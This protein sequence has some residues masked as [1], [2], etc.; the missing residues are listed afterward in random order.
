MTDSWDEDAEGGAFGALLQAVADTPI[1]SPRLDPG[2][3]VAT[4]YEII[5]PLGE[6]G[7]GVVFLAK[8][9]RLGRFVA[10]K[11]HNIDTSGD[12][13]RRALREASAMSR[14]QDP[15]V[16]AV[17][18][19]GE[20][21]EGQLYIA[22]EHV[23]GPTLRQWLHQRPRSG[24]EIIEAFLE[25]AQGL[26]AAHRAG[27]VH[28]DVKPDNLLIGRDG[29]VRVADFGLAG[30]Q[31]DLSTGIGEQL[32]DL[33]ESGASSRSG[34]FAG[35]PTY[36][37]PEQWLRAPLDARSDQYSFCAALF[38]ALY[39]VPPFEG[40]STRELRA[41]VE[42]GKIRQVDDAAP[43]TPSRVRR[44][45][46]RGLRPD[47]ADRYADMEALVVALRRLLQLRRRNQR[48][49]AMAA[50][51]AASA[52]FAVWA[53]D[54]S[55]C[56]GESSLSRFW[57][58]ARRSAAQGALAKALEDPSEA[59]RAITRI[60]GYVDDWS[61]ER[62]AA[63]VATVVDGSQSE[64]MLDRRM[65][66]LSDR[67][68]TVQ[69]LIQT[70]KAPD[71]ERASRALRSA[72]DLPQISLCADRRFL[73][74]WA[75]PPATEADAAEVER[76]RE[77]LARAAAEVDGGAFEAGLAEAMRIASAADRLGYRP[78]Q[79]E[80]WALVG[81]GQRWLGNFASSRA[82]L[83]KAY[84]LALEAGHDVLAISVATALVYVLSFDLS[85]HTRAIE[86]G[87][88]AEA[89][90][91]RVGGAGPFR[92]RL[93]MNLGTAL[94]QAGRFGEALEATEKAVAD[95]ERVHGPVHADV[96]TALTRH[97]SALAAKGDAA[98]A[99]KTLKRAV[100]MTEEVFGEAHRELHR[101]LAELGQAL[102]AV[103]DNA[104]AIE[105]Q[106]RALDICRSAFGSTHVNTG[107]AELNLG[108]A[109]H[110]AGDLDAA[111]RHYRRAARI[112]EARLGPDHRDTALCLT[113]LALTMKDVPDEAAALHRRVLRIFERQGA[114]HVDV[115]RARINLA[116][117]LIDARDYE[118]ALIE[119]RR[120]TKIWDEAAHDAPNVAFALHLEGLAELGAGRPAAAVAPLERAVS[121]RAKADFSPRYLADS[122]FALARALRASGKEK[123][124][125]RAAEA[126]LQTYED[127][128]AKERETVRTWLS[129]R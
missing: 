27:L 122:R 80:C 85:E 77:A 29:R 50:A 76:L 86:W 18:D 116:R 112:V 55:P 75:P 28:R 84:F 126:A 51:L 99:V 96:A 3:L 11:L 66:C 125:R 24:P 81:R 106:G 90:V 1:V 44:V 4:H 5:E 121:I 111:G 104:G 14:L 13:R 31:A 114:E 9:L 124:A 23:D 74:A 115:G 119:A 47:P 94:E 110:F 56:D 64:Q 57:S 22:M 63:C 41:N 54:R 48:V 40:E 36:A 49:A 108:V 69:A 89:A 52:V 113:N 8:D 105:V 109:H 71:P 101:P 34:A 6:G 58:P 88:H 59:R 79:A 16:V 70:W 12:T 97:G 60:D 92:G 61:L 102:S 100:E 95:L 26:A 68:R 17:F 10:L 93:L 78:L 98:A 120:A 118:S 123:R 83:E 45:I 7:M 82:S 21:R 72:I 127:L 37:P 129:S 46:E 25:A 73:M 43:K 32:D 103:G 15:N 42:A 107:F 30:R 38:E 128:E 19:V 53:V 87:R 62:R 33:A 91:V 39:G 20:V 35:T 2:T 65:A 117:A 67:A